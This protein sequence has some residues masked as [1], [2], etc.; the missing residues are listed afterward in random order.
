MNPKGKSQQKP[1]PQSKH[2]NLL[3]FK[4][5]S[6][7]GFGMEGAALGCEESIALKGVNCCCCVD[8]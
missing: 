1:T 5:G 2:I 8:F 4:G 7:D 6:E 3:I